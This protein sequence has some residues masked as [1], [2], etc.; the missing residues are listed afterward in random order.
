[1][2]MRRT[3]FRSYD[4]LEQ[5]REWAEASQCCVWGIPGCLMPGWH[6]PEECHTIEM[7]ENFERAMEKDDETEN[8]DS[9]RQG[10]AT[11]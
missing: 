7:V 10:A 5:Y 4:E 6:E 11:D 9:Q 2:G 1:M 3:H 8:G